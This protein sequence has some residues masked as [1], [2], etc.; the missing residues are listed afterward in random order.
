MKLPINFTL[1]IL[2]CQKYCFL[3]K[4]CRTLG[5]PLRLRHSHARASHVCLMYSDY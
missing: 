2:A 4:Y 1:E 5:L 3:A